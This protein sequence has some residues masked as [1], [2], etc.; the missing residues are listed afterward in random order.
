MLTD[1]EKWQFD[2][3]GFLIL[4]QVLAPDDLSRMVA[5]CDEWHG[6][7][8]SELPPPLSSYEDPAKNPDS[9]RAILDPE[10]ADP[11]F[12]RLIL[13]LQI[14][15]AVL[16]ITDNAPQHLLSA[17]TV[18]Q[19]DSNEIGLHG[20]T[21]GSIR[22]PANDYQ[23][24]DGRVFAT[25]L[26]AAI[27]LVNVPPGSGFVCIPGSHKSYFQRPEDVDIYTGPPTVV[28]VP[29]NAGDAVIFT[30]TLCHGALPW[31]REDTPRRTVFVRYSTSYASWSP[32]AGPKEDFKDRLSEDVYQMKQ[33]WPF[34]G[35]KPVVEKLIEQLNG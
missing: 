25:F 16:D 24:G 28:N 27:S 32:G 33:Q 20:G 15:R 12:D 17:L 26:N 1:D 19:T 14:M 3:H 29:I 7:S 6:L 31:L 21:V 5:L 13:N 9:A 34:Q 23:A 22:N 35:K 18:N 30:E 4:K 11:V 10:Y 2:L 8:E